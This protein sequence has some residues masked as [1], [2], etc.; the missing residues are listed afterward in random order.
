[1]FKNVTVAFF[2]ACTIFLG[3]GWSQE[4]NDCTSAG[5]AALFDGTV[6][7]LRAA[8]EIFSL[9]LEDEDCSDDREL[10]FLQAI[11]RIAMWAFRDDGLPID[12]AV[13][14]GSE[15]NVKLVNDHYWALDL[16]A[17]EDFFPLNEHDSYDVPE[18]GESVLSDLFEFMTH[19]GVSEIESVIDEFDRIQE[20][21]DDRFRMFLTPQETAMFFGPGV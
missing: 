18:D 10:I 12:S 16:V 3:Q 7:G 17:G 8:H 2:L 11:T 21:P 13:E 9:R 6:S 5:R 4:I 15:N 20:T 19:A 14:F 1:M